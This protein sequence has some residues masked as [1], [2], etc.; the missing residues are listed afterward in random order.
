MVE[1]IIL[2]CIPDQLRYRDEL[3]PLRD[4]PEPPALALSE[5]YF[6]DIPAHARKNCRWEDLV[7]QAWAVERQLS[8]LPQV[9]FLSR[10]SPFF[11]PRLLSIPL[12]P[13]GLFVRGDVKALHGDTLLAVVGT[14][15]P[16]LY[17][18]QVV[19]L[20]L[21]ALESQEFTLV[22]GLAYGIDS[23]AHAMAL[24][25]GAL[26]VAVLAHGIDFI[27]PPGSE[28]LAQSILRGGGA[29]ISEYPPGEPPYKSRFTHRNRLVSGLSHGVWVVQG[30]P[31]SGTRATANHAAE[32]GRDL[33]ATPGS[34]FSELA[35]VPHEI[36][37]TGGT[38]IMDAK[39]LRQFLG[40]AAPNKIQTDFTLC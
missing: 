37:R 34:I 26:N 9:R 2:C 5:R 40:L 31:R 6:H 27:Y 4:L 24:R 18:T 30:G 21:G 22:S 3:N 36:L 1:E 39:D 25:R 29:V 12:S 23:A 32:Q 8:T 35:T 11:P 33:G 19:E 38:P 28:P 15:R 17:G 10:W 13:W 20:L 7:L 14:R 16:N